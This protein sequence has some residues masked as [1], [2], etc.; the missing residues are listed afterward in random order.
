MKPKAHRTQVS[1]SQLELPLGRPGVAHDLAY[2]IGI[3][4][5]FA[6]YHKRWPTADASREEFRA[7][8]V[9]DVDGQRIERALRFPA[10][11]LEADPEYRGLRE[12]CLLDGMRDGVSLE[13]LDPRYRTVLSDSGIAGLFA[14]IALPVKAGADAVR[15][16]T[17]LPVHSIDELTLR[18]GQ[19]IAMHALGAAGFD[20]HDPR[21]LA[22]SFSARVQANDEL[23]S[24]ID[25]IGIH[26]PL[27]GVHLA[28]HY[29]LDAGEDGRLTVRYQLLAGGRYAGRFDVGQLSAKLASVY[30]A[31]P[32]LAQLRATGAAQMPATP[33]MPAAPAPGSIEELREQLA[34]LEPEG[35]SLKLPI[36]ALSRF[37]DIRRLLGKAGGDYRASGQRF[38]FEEG[39]DPAALVGRLLKDGAA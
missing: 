13:A 35:Q 30:A 7:A 3:C 12:R 1:S 26:R 10:P 32:E 8:R 24:V 38:D 21:V 29:L 2:Y 27:L 34:M 28:D 19:G 36:Q 4:K 6:A 17:G 39:I 11:E 5:V 31:D 9:R 15:Y 37:A 25:R 33:A 16:A 20:P 22:R 18:I 14:S 23:K